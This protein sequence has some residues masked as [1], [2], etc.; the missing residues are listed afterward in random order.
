MVDESREGGGS[1]RQMNVCVCVCVGWLVGWLVE[2]RNAQR[3]L[4]SL[5]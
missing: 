5:T 4:T 2:S 1:R 3:R